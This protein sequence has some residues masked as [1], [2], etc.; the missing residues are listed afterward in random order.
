MIEVELEDGTVLEV[1]ADNEADAAKIARRFMANQRATEYRAKQGPVARGLDAFGRGFADAATLGFADEV[2][3]NLGAGSIEDQRALDRLDEQNA[4]GQRLLGQVAGSIAAPF[5]ALPA[6]AAAAFT[7]PSRAV[8]MGANALQGGAYM[9]GSAEGGVADRADDFAVGALLSP[10]MAEGAR[11]LTNRIAGL[12]APQFAPDVRTLQQAGV[13]LTPGQ[14]FGGRANAVE[15]KMAGTAPIAGNL[16]TQ[17][18]NESI[19]QFGLGAVN[20]ALAPLK[21]TLPAGTP[22]Q[23]AVGKM[24]RATST[25]YDR[26][27][28]RMTARLDPDF[29]TVLRDAAAASKSGELSADQAEQFGKLIQSKVAFRF[30]QSR[31]IGGKALQQTLSDL[32]RLSAENPGPMGS[33]LREVSDG[34]EQSAMRHS[35]SGAVQTF[36]KARDAYAGRTVVERAASAAAGS[37]AD[38]QAGAFTPGQLMTAVRQSDRT[39]RKGA[40]A[41]GE[42]RLQKYATAGQNVLPQTVGNPGT[43]DRMIAVGG[44]AGLG[45]GVMSGMLDPTTAALIGGAALTS[46]APYTKA[47]TG[48]FN[49]LTMPRGPR[50]EAVGSGLR[51]VAPLLGLGLGPAA[52]QGVA[53]F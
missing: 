4:G 47:G 24:Q 37:A 18:R 29:E 12:V 17:R 20:Q 3:G 46:A 52:V 48:I 30:G 21:M 27:I 10:L 34:L 9:A 35:P 33:L 25:M 39:A 49:A 44:G 36:Q 19:E 43:A 22:T 32:R 8:R 53:G 51:R 40:T 23:E 13:K 42:A 5:A 2:A 1:D 26:A 15:S 7:A 41:R 38:R 16:I 45:A 6:R 31:T 50:A 14:A 11:G 28:R